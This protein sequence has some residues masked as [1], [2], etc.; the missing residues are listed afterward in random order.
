[1]SV[2]VAVHAIREGQR[3]LEVAMD[4]ASGATDRDM[5]ARQGILR[6]CVVE[7]KSRQQL[8][9]SRRGVTLFAPLLERAPVRVHVAI[10]ARAKLHVLVPRGTARHFRLMALFAGYL[11]M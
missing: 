4:V 10:C 5:L 9:P 6:L 8:L 2:L 7:R 1:M 11:N 3:L